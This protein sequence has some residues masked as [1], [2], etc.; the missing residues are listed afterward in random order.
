MNVKMQQQLISEIA[1]L[2]ARI[3]MLEEDCENFAEVINEVDELMEDGD[4]W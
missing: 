4:E 3:T 2:K 1:M